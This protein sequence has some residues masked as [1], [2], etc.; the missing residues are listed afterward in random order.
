MEDRKGV[1]V[2][3][4]DLRTDRRAEWKGQ[5]DANKKLNLEP[6]WTLVK[7]SSRDNPKCHL[8]MFCSKAA[9]QCSVQWP[10]RYGLLFKPTYRTY[11][12]CQ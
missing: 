2:I 8:D 5:V 7:M 12:L 3:V 9:D 4:V 10:V 1:E 6:K 11:T